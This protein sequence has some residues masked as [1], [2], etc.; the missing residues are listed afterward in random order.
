MDHTSDPNAMRYVIDP[1]R[2]DLVDEFRTSPL[3]IHSPDLR[4]LLAKMRWGRAQG[5]LVLVV[6]EAGKAWRLSRIPE[7]RG[8]PMPFVD[9]RIFTSLA[10]AEWHVFKIR[11][12]AMTGIS[13]PAEYQGDL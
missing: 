2:L 13:L 1:N 5:R 12:Q 10:E 6:L 7:R 8:D 3:G 11:W 9:D 4:A